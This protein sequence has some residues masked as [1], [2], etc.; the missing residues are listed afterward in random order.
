MFRIL[1]LMRLCIYISM[2]KKAEVKINFLSVKKVL[3]NDSVW[4]NIP[5]QDVLILQM[6]R[7]GT[8]TME[9]LS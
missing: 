4:R 2:H 8:I 5:M 3:K 1:I 6:R 9:N 7:G